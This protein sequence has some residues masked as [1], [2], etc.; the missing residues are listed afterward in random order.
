MLDSSW[1]GT[2]VEYVE[3]DMD[4]EGNERELRTVGGEILEVRDGTW[5]TP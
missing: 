2:R 4:K 5:V 1:V 3:Y